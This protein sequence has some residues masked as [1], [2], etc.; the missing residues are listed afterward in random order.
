MYYRLNEDY[1]LRAWKFV[2]N[3]IYNRY[4]A[5]PIRVDD[6]TFELLK[7]CDGDHDLQESDALKNLTEQG[8]VSPCHQDEQP[9]E[10][11]RYRKYE[12]RFMPDIF[13]RL[14][15]CLFR[16]GIVSL[17]P[18]RVKTTPSNHFPTILVG[19][20]YSCPSRVSACGSRLDG[21]RAEAPRSNSYF[22]FFAYE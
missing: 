6:D 9:S 14:G 1:A 15:R 11:S 19:R 20:L 17:F 2:S 3:V 21:G 12:H 8:I 7:S 16:W 22:C 5:E 18:S 10:W 4:A 13:T